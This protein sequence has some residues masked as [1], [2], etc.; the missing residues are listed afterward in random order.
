MGRYTQGIRQVLSVYE[1]RSEPLIAAI[2]TLIATAEENAAAANLDAALA[3][4]C[5]Q[6]HDGPASGIKCR[7]CY[8]V[9]QQFS[10]LKQVNADIEM[11]NARAKNEND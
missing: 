2:E 8:E 4:H 5:E 11:A 1:P 10:M 3:D 9:E 6:M 7:K